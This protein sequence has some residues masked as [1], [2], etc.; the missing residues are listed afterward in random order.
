MTS[1]VYLNG[2]FVER[3]DAK[4]SIDDGGW[5]HGAGLFETMCSENGRVF[6]LSAHLDRLRK[7]AAHLLREISLEQLPSE[8]DFRTL[9]QRNELTNA[10]LRL[11]VSAGSMLAGVDQQVPL[12]ICVTATALARPSPSFYGKGVTACLS[13][14]RQSPS[15][16]L[17]GHKTTA[18]LGRL[19]GMREAQQAKCFDAIW[20]TTNN[21][22]AEGSVS[23]VFVVKD[24]M[25]KTPTLDTPVLPGV[26]RS[27]ILSLAAKLDIKRVESTLSIDD[28]LD[29]DEVFLTNAIMQVMPVCQVEKR[30]IGEGIVGPVTKK[31]MH[32]YRDCVA[33][34]CVDR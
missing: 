27:V 13:Q 22:L 1:T 23:N 14:Y 11:T 25:I 34:E 10:R 31:L 24:D 21:H 19:L 28:L 30:V 17:C 15:D 7:S 6:K 18:Y 8:G 2:E 26:A 29:A 32:A 20:F 16:P 9:L 4:I 33:K 5:L 3:A 12:T